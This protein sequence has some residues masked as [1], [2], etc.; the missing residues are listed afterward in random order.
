M[1]TKIMAQ[2]DTLRDQPPEIDIDW[3]D[4][5]HT[6]LDFF[7]RVIPKVVSSERCSIFIHDPSQQQVWL[8]A[9]TGVEEKQIDVQ[10]DADSIVGDVIS[11]GKPVIINNME[12]RPGIHKQ[13][14]RDTGFV[15]R[16]IMCIPIRSLDGKEV[17]GAVQLLNR[18]YGH[19]FSE[20]DLALM[21]EIC[22]FIEQSLENIYFRS[23]TEV[24]V[25]KATLITRVSGV[26]GLLLLLGTTGAF[27]IWAMW[28]AVA[29]F[30]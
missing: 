14:D 30:L 4:V 13:I 9:G 26:G 6:L 23:K 16:D 12:D 3:E 15:T 2:F 27:T 11:T 24:L 28:I 29:S 8:K 20:D 7:V 5:H 10:L 17:T 21:Q 18:M 25:H 19:K 1:F 22:H